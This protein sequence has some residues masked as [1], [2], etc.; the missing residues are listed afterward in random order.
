M[1]SSLLI[2]YD[3]GYCKRY[4]LVTYA[5]SSSGIIHNMV[6]W[7]QNRKERNVENNYVIYF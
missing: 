6:K 1:D 2:D 3:T 5:D 7:I 4:Y